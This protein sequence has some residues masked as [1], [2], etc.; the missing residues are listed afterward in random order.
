VHRNNCNILCG[1]FYSLALSLI[2]YANIGNNGPVSVKPDTSQMHS[3]NSIAIVD[4]DVS[5]LDILSQSLTLE[6]YACDTY[7]RAEDA[8]DALG[9]SPV[10]VLLTDIVMPGMRGLE[11]V[12][13]V[14][15]MHPQ[16]T[17]IV[18]TGFAEEFSYEGAMRAGA[19]DFIKKP[20]GVQELLVRIKHAKLQDHLRELSITDE[21]TGLANRR[22]FFAFAQQQLKQTRRTGERLVLLYADLD[23]LKALN[24]SEGHLAGDR[25][26]AET[27]RIFRE[28]FRDSDIIARMGGDEFAVILI[29]VPDEG[30]AAA[31]N[32]LQKR[33][34][35]YNSRREVTGH[36]AISTG[37]SVFDP[38]KPCSLDEL[39]READARMYYEKQRK[40]GPA[41]G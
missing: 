17:V 35:A 20:F 3:K 32:R 25:A 5:I 21:L 18:M 1:A 26:L 36:L 9:R 12:N 8:L 11:L 19:A 38:A 40:K 6:G 31:Q 24:D 13:R 39:L 34:D 28:T 2:N 33:L 30:V 16:I 4:D 29:N 22:G 23:N 27:A 41:P 7:T 15:E 10:E 37:L 14:K